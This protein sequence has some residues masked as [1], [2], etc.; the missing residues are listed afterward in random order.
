M[1]YEETP[2]KKATPERANAISKKMAVKATE[3]LST[4]SIIWILAKRHKVAILAVGNIVL[5]LNWSFPEWTQL[6]KS[7]IN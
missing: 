6:V 3:T 4:P 1:T 2:I 5:I 7:L